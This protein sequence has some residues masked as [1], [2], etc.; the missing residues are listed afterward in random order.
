MT[1]IHNWFPSAAGNNTGSAPDFPIEGMAPASINDVIRENM[2]AI[3][4]NSIDTNGSIDST[5]AGNAYL[6]AT[7][8]IYTGYVRGMMYMFRANHANTGAATLNVTTGAN[9]SLGAK[10]IVGLN[11]SAVEAGQIAN[12]SICFVVYDD[13]SGGRFQLIATSRTAYSQLQNVSATD[14]VLGRASAGAGVVEE[15]VCTAA[16]RAILAAADAPAQR[17]ALGLGSLSTASAI[18]NANWNGAAL[19]VANGGTGATTAAGARTALGL[20]ALATLGSVNNGNW[21]GAALTIANGGTGAT[22]A[23]AARTALGL[24]ALAV[25]A[26]INNGNW[27][28]T[29]LTIANGGT[30]ASDAAGARSNLGIKS[31]ALRDVT[32]STNAPSGGVDGDI[33]LQYIA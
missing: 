6:L 14:R 8:A 25:L 7:R 18:N 5:G 13:A 26:N 23:A 19:T 29:D 1:D 22:T 21:N 3:R 20:G 33:H 28:G 4:R 10:P 16:G 32:I 17:A 2:A 30:G 15:I 12:G 31:M 11:G 9:P 24:G 27:S